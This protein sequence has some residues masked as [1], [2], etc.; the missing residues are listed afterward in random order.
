MLFV[1]FADFNNDRALLV[2]FKVLLNDY[3]K[4]KYIQN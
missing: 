1:V 3:K 2:H 4:I